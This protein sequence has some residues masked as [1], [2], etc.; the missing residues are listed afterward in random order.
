MPRPSENANALVHRAPRTGRIVS[1]TNKFHRRTSIRRVHVSGMPA[2]NKDSCAMAKQAKQRYNVQ[3]R[4]QTRR[5]LTPPTP[6]AAEMFTTIAAST[7]KCQARPASAWMPPT[8][9]RDSPTRVFNLPSR[10]VRPTTQEVSQEAIAAIDHRLA[11]T[12]V[13]YIRDHIQK[14]GFGRA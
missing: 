8:P 1:V 13:G 6:P 4:K 5:A 10:L 12:P 9:P 7:P 3:I 11:D 14:S 2:L